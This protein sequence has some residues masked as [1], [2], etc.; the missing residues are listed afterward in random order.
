MPIPV[1]EALDEQ[2]ALGASK[3]AS[4]RRPAVFVVA[5]ALAGGFVGVGVVLLLSVAGPFAA[6]GSPATRLVGGAVFGIALTLVVFAGGELATGSMMV[7]TQSAATG[8]LRWTGAVAVV[9]VTLVGNLVGAVLFSGAVAAS[10]IVSSGPSAEL[11]AET[12]AVKDSLGLGE[13]FWR[14]VLCN[15]LVCLGLWMAA[16]TRSDAAK[17]IVL[18]WALLG[19]VASGFEHSVANMTTFS[20][21]VFTADATWGQLA[22]NLAVTIPGNL[23]GGALVVGGAYVLLG[24]SGGVTASG[25]VDSPAG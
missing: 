25:E 11:L 7:V 12:I 2:A 8:R 14:A 21:G 17:L 23:V 5:A 22:R 1:A 3:A 20:L 24:R 6:A 16:R 10:G 9:A 4:L 19:F 13:L 18:W 15:A